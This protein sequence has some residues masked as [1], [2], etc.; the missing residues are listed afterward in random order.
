MVWIEA[1][2]CFRTILGFNFFVAWNELHFS[3]KRNL[4]KK[5]Q[6]Q[7]EKCTKRSKMDKKYRKTMNFEFWTVSFACFFFAQTFWEYFNI[8]VRMQ[9]LFPALYGLCMFH[10]C[11]FVFS[12]KFDLN[13]SWL[14]C[15]WYFKPFQPI[16]CSSLLLRFALR[17]YSNHIWFGH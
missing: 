7:P 10:C 2:C 17:C 15:V 9:L 3:M 16:Y 6:R 14:L 12:T 5:K 1:F 4:H 11:A 13:E 8:F